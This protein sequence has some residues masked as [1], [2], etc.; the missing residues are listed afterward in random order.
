MN[1]I[2]PLT[3]FRFWA[4]KVIPLVYDESLS[5]Y[6]LLCKVVDY[7]NKMG[8]DFNEL[9]ENFN[10]LS[11]D[12]A[13]LKTWVETEFPE[14]VNNKLDEMAEDGTLTALIAPY[15]P[16]VTP[17]MFGA[18]GD[19]VTDDTEAI[20]NAVNAGYHI[21]FKRT[22]TY[23]ITDSISINSNK[24]LDGDGATITNA[25]PC[26]IFTK[27]ETPVSKITIKNFNLTGAGKNDVT[28]AWPDI[29]SAIVI[30]TEA[31]DILVEKCSFT[32]FPYG[33]FVGGEDG[34]N[35][36]IRDCYF[37]D[38][39]SAVDTF[40][41]NNGKVINCWFDSCTNPIQL[42]TNVNT[43][44]HDFIIAENIT[45][46]TDGN[47]SLN[48]HSRISNVD[49]FNNNF[50]KGTTCTAANVTKLKIHNNILGGGNGFSGYTDII[51]NE[52]Y[53]ASYLESNFN[54]I[55]KGNYIDSDTY[56]FQT[57]TTTVAVFIDNTAKVGTAFVIDGG[58]HAV[59]VGL[60]LLS[61]EIA[62]SVG[63]TDIVFYDYC[64]VATPGYANYE[65]KL[66]SNWK[67]WAVPT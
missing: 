39:K 11:E 3:P 47:W 17:E 67:Y 38:C 8:V 20:Q 40:V 32:D 24:V 63:W 49:V 12:F 30:A 10:E 35:A 54:G 27:G 41:T 61:G 9:L 21:I 55:V 44:T 2:K 31:S 66:N 46:N 59:I 50:D 1:E 19:G 4:Q 57:Q 36:I 52:I 53:G 18:I 5:Y 22:S 29:N 25:E 28:G 65:A 16:F 56:G 34:K 62:S 58:E 14:F 45:L 48:L 26:R 23:K 6:E 42:E 15:L 51:N 33:V 7:L 37:K 60:R 13:N 64:G 43:T